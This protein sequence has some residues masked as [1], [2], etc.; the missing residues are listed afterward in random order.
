[1]FAIAY[2]YWILNSITVLFIVLKTTLWDG[3]AL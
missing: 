1:M 2:L 3:G